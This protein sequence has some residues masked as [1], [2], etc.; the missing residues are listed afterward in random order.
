DEG[1]GTDDGLLEGAFEPLGVRIGLQPHLVVGVDLRVRSDGAVAAA[2]DDVLRLGD[3]E[4]TDDG[5][6]G[7]SDSGDDDSQ[8]P[9]PLTLGVVSGVRRSQRYGADAVVVIGDDRYV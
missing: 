4:Q 5:V 8:F 7:R 9:A 2:G 1:V 3:L 6:A